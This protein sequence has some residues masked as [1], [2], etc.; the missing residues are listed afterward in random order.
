MIVGWVYD[1]DSKEMML[2][3][4]KAAKFLRESGVVSPDVGIIL[5][6]G[7]NDYSDRITEGVSIDYSDIPGFC[8]GKAQ[9]HK[10]KLVY[11]EHN[12][13][14]IAILAGRFH[15]YEG[16][17]ME[18]T[19]FPVRV[20]I[21]M[22]IKRL[23]ITNAS[24]CINENFSEGQFMLIS[25]HINMSG[26]NPLIGENLEAY[27]K[28]FPDM[29]YTYDEALR[30]KLKIK[31]KG[32]GVNLAE[33]VYAMMSG[34]SFET[35]S[36]IRFLRIIGADAVGMS[37]VPEAIVANHAGLEIIGISFLSNMAAGIID[38]PLLGEDVNHQAKNAERTFEKIVDIAVEI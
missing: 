5:G 6:S 9:G 19:V 37:T 38:K 21:E 11:G 32:I 26:E 1:M 18:K 3:I 29:T 12:G 34:P 31:A 10:G 28:R 35:P 7:L 20:L 23:I 33:G 24:G 8:V 2:K 15:Y 14:E 4:E 30:E 25:D 27:G 36:E 17:S 13:K 22:G 16:H